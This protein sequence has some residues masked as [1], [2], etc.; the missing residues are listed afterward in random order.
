MTWVCSTLPRTISV[1][2]HGDAPLTL[3]LDYGLEIQA[4]FRICSCAKAP[5]SGPIWTSSITRRS[6]KAWNPNTLHRMAGSTRRGPM[7]KVPGASPCGSWIGTSV[8]PAFRGQGT[9]PALVCQLLE[10]TRAIVGYRRMRPLPF[11]REAVALHRKIGFTDIPCYN[12]SPMA[13]TISLQLELSSLPPR[14]L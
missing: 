6:F 4:L 11:L 5:A 2:K 13:E 1:C 3:T 10:D 12:N 7:A 9:A 8:R 14:N